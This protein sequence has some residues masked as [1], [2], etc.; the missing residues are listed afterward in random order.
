MDHNLIEKYQEKNDR[1]ILEKLV[2]DYTYLIKKQVDKMSYGT[3]PGISRDDLISF[4][5][6][7]LI[8]S[9]NKFDLTRGVPFA[10]YARIRIRGAILDGLREFDFVPRRIR[11]EVR[12]LYNK[13]QELEKL[14]GRAPTNQEIS[15]QL[16]KPIEEIERLWKEA[17]WIV[18]TYLSDFISNQDKQLRI[19]DVYPNENSPN[20]EKCLNQVDIRDQLGK[21]IDSL[22]EKEKL[23]LSL[24]YYEELT[25]KEISQ[26]MDL[27]ESR[28]SQLHSK[29]IMRLRGK[30][31]N[32]KWDI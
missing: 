8:D 1:K 5:V 26:V 4:G 25:L 24:Y 6:I 11:D 7:G 31:T 21:V 19:Q 30:L 15:E 17:S 10:A 3:P 2:E 16:S 9:I 20:P 27:S 29:G 22:P 28:I 18:P 32:K 12:T 14:L 23:V 13:C